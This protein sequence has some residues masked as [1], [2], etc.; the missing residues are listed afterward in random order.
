MGREKGGYGKP[1]GSEA[2]WQ[3]FPDPEMRDK[4]SKLVK[5]GRKQEM[6]IQRQQG[7]GASGDLGGEKVREDASQLG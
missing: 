1:Q 2:E 6:Q 7:L 3:Q 4:N 5:L